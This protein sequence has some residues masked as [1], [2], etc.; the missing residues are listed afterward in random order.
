MFKHIKRTEELR[1]AQAEIKRLKA[2]VGEMPP[3]DVEMGE[4]AEQETII[5]KLGKND[6]ELAE[7]KMDTAGSNA[8]LFEMVLMMGGF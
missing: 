7:I 1:L 5:G 2:L 6:K 3:Q 8:E 4:E